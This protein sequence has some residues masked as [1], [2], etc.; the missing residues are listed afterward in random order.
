M[1]PGQSQESNDLR[2][3]LVWRSFPDSKV[4]QVGDSREHSPLFAHN[5]LDA[6]RFDHRSAP[7]LDFADDASI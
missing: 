5:P 7:E 4:R 1:V 6:L 2:L 3:D